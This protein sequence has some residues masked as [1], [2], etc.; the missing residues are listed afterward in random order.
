MADNPII[1]EIM[2]LAAIA[3]RRA[4]FDTL[5][6]ALCEL[7]DAKYASRMLDPKSEFY[8][9]Q[10]DPFKAVLREIQAGKFRTLTEDSAV[11]SGGIGAHSE[12]GSIR[13]WP[14]VDLERVET[15]ES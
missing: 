15:H 6:V 2:D 11:T 9:F 1:T 8:P 4:L 3:D 14:G 7:V 13:E 10:Q 5:Q 12:P